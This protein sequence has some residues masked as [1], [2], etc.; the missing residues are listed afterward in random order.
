MP[1]S[2]VPVLVDSR[3]NLWAAV[4]EG[5]ICS[6]D[7]SPSMRLRASFSA[8]ALRPLREPEDWAAHSVRLRAGL[9]YASQLPPVAGTTPPPPPAAR[10][11]D[12]NV[13]I[14]TLRSE[15]RKAEAECARGRQRER[16]LFKVVEGLC[17]LHAT[18]P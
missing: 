10:G 14:N 16:A 2:D 4:A 6:S 15:L 13:A 18:P 3:K 7:L 9:P 8:T 12:E 17:E 11:N 5:V 1:R